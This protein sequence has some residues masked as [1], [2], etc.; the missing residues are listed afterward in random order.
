MEGE[1][2]GKRIKESFELSLHKQLGCLDVL[3]LYKFDLQNP[4]HGK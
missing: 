2:K 3:N 4:E 1:L